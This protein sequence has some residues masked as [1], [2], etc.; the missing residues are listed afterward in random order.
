M[1]FYV[2]LMLL[3]YVR[4]IFY[5]WMF[6]FTIPG[7]EVKEVFKTHFVYTREHFFW[8]LLTGPSKTFVDYLW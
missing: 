3:M 8:I 4:L 6:F 5:V 7:S 2:H 1:F